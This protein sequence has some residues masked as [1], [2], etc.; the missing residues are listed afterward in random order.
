MLTD[1]LAANAGGNPVVLARRPRADAHPETVS[2]LHVRSPGQ[3]PQ[4]PEG[5][6]RS[7]DGAERR[8]AVR[9]RRESCRAGDEE[10]GKVRGGRAAPVADN[11]AAT[12]ARWERWSETDGRWA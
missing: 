11:D 1:W 3:M 8:R 2:G 10:R 12:C 4:T 6:R 9:R 7:A 5:R